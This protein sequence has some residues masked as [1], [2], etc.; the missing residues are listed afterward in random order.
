MT[1]FT[2]AREMKISKEL[3]KIKRTLQVY[4]GKSSE[5]VFLTRR[6]IG[7]RLGEFSLTKKLGSKIHDSARNKKR[8][9]KQRK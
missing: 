1:D 7:H 5:A 3:L 6:M 9:N 2:R 8:K 4:K